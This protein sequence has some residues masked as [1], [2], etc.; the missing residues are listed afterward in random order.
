MEHVEKIQPTK[1]KKGSKND[2]K[3]KS[4]SVTDS[5]TSSILFFKAL[6]LQMRIANHP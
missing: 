6:A 5:F 3:N 2:S 4:N 1:V